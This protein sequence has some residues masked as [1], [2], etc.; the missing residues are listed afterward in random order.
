MPK[1][2]LSSVVAIIMLSPILA[3]ATP[4]TGDKPGRAQNVVLKAEWERAQLIGGYEDP[5][6]AL[7]N[8]FN[9]TVTERTLQ[10]K[11]SVQESETIEQYKTRVAKETPKRQ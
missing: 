4:R 2:V 7:F 1:I 10:P 9:G 8:V 11:I 3:S 6:T 5:L